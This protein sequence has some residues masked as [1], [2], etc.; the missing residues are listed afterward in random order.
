MTDYR[1]I[2]ISIHVCSPYTNKVVENDHFIY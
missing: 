1:D 2:C